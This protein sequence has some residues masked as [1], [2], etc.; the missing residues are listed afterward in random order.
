ML[1]CLHFGQNRGKSLSTVL[2]NILS[3]VFA[4]QT[5]HKTRL[6]SAV[7]IAVAPW[8]GVSVNHAEKETYVHPEPL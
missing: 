6:S 1:S 7:L 3:R 2:C 5:G 4:P 8:G